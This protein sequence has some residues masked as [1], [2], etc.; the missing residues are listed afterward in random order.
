MKRNIAKASLILIVTALVCST[1]FASKVNQVLFENSTDKTIRCA[2]RYQVGQSKWRITKWI[3][4]EPGQSRLAANTQA[5]TVYYYAESLDQEY[6]WS[7]LY[8]YE[9]EG[10]LRNFKEMTLVNTNN[11]NKGILKHI[12]FK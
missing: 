3:E 10:D 9:V 11:S 5:D 7:G 1:A 4:L 12:N 2:I 8:E 6:T